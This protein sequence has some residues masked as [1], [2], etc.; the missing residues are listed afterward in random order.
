MYHVELRQFP[1]NFCRFNLT[2]RALREAVLDAWSQGEW[3]EFGER[4]WNPHQA[5]LTV[6]EGPQL[7]LEQLSMGRG[8]RAAEREG[9]NVTEQLLAAVRADVDS[10][11]EADARGEGTTSNL[12]TSSR[13]AGSLRKATASESATD[14]E[15][16]APGMRLLADSLG[17]EVLARLGEEEPVA[18]MIV[19]QLARE[20]HPEWAASDCLELAEQSVRSLLRSRLAVVLLEDRRGELE[21]CV[22]EEQV[23]AALR[24][25]EGWSST[26]SSA[27][28]LIRRA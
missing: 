3:I 9:K 17:L 1:H 10:T 21:P 20:R 15:A 8:W 27:S 24:P 26:G 25:I 2:E 16:A 19:W 5:Q 7:P 18:L 22:S 14:V 11:S 6:I 4:K 23:E 28:V 12:T 13:G